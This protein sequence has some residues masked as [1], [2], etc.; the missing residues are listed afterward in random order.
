MICRFIHYN[1]YIIVIAIVAIISRCMTQLEVSNL[2]WMRRPRILSFGVWCWMVYSVPRN[3]WSSWQ[4]HGWI[5]EH[6]LW[7]LVTS[8]TG[9]MD[10]ITK[11]DGT[12]TRAKVPYRKPWIRYNTRMNGHSDNVSTTYS[13]STCLEMQAFQ[14]PYRIRLRL[15]TTMSTIISKDQMSIYTTRRKRQRRSITV[16]VTT[17]SVTALQPDCINSSIKNIQ[18]SGTIWMELQAW[19][20]W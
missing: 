17:P 3:D 18:S 6:S 1:Y 2:A 7:L 9:R 10:H 15:D 13:W 19:W 12:C 5:M 4:Q 16:H 20:S 11:V 14:K 8:P